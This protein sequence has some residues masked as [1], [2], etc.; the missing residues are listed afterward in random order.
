MDDFDL[1]SRLQSVRHVALDL[2]GTVYTD[3]TLLPNSL[4]FLKVLSDRGI[5]HSFLT[6]NSSRG[7]QD[8]LPLLQKMGIPAEA[9]HI[10]TSADATIEYLKHEMPNVKSIWLLGTPSLS[11]Q[12]RNYGFTVY[13]GHDFHEGRYGS[14]EPDAVVLGFD[15]TLTFD[16]ICQASWWV[17][18]GKP[19]LATHPD[20]VCPTNEE[21]VLIDC[22]AVI[23]AIAQATGRT[24]DVVPG[25][26]DP[27]MLDGICKRH[28][29]KRNELVMV[30]DRLYTDM[31]MAQRAGALSV[32]VLTGEATMDEATQMPEVPDL[33]LSD[34]GAFGKLLQKTL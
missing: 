10:Y 8:Y 3:D 33:I 25:K 14:P 9:S 1:K 30:G 31:A 32:L 21:T 20:M 6:N 15:R 18:Q 7:T 16:R 17:S 11:Q 29:I 4:G 12:F 2:D 26:P 24:P 22:G 28:G 19:Y 5:G 27:R 23:A 34:L 13:D